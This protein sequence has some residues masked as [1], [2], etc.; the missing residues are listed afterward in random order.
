MRIDTKFENG[1]TVFHAYVGD[2]Y[3]SIPCDECSEAGWLKVE[4]KTYKIACRVCNGRGSLATYEP[5]PRA[6]MMMIGQVRI[7]ITESPGKPGYSPSSNFGPQREREESYMCV[8]TGIGS[9][10]IYRVEDLFAT[11]QEA[12]VRAAFKVIEW[13]ERRAEAEKH[14]AA[15][16]LQREKEYRE[17][18]AEETAQS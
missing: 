11:E 1:D 7:S 10:T 18:E 15:A 12:L 4:G 2:G 16:R 17:E 9:G 8:E 5:M 14:E 6:T 3:K 13:K